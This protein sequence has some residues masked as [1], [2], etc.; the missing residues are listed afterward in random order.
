ME[1]KK[2]DLKKNLNPKE[3]EL[4]EDF[5]PTSKIQIT[6]IIIQSIKDIKTYYYIFFNFNLYLKNLR[7]RIHRQRT[8]KLQNPKARRLSKNKKIQKLIGKQ[9]KKESIR[10]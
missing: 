5:I 7:R 2:K 8:N 10:L 1:R 9:P 4:S 6:F 3:I